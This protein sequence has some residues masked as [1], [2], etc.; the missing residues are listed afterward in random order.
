MNKL[1][2]LKFSKEARKHGYITHDKLLDLYSDEQEI[3]DYIITF[4]IYKPEPFNS[5]IVVENLYKE[6][7]RATKEY[8][9]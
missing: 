4:L 8:Y 6:I 1:E 3:P 9:E 2:V 5:M 7:L